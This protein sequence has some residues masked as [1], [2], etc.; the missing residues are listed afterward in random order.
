MVVLNWSA[1]FCATL[2]TD[3][4]KPLAVVGCVRVPP[5]V[6]ASSIVGVNGAAIELDN[7]LG[8]VCDC[9]RRCLMLSTDERDLVG[10]CFAAG[11]GGNVAFEGSVGVGGVTSVVG[12]SGSEL[13]VFSLVL[14]GVAVGV[15]DSVCCSLKPGAVAGCGGVSGAVA[16]STCGAC[17]DETSSSGEDSVCADVVS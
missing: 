2:K 17:I 12:V 15:D 14:R 6:L 11:L 7:L 5:G 10:D 13:E 9:A 8:R 3:E 1:A 4:K 16:V